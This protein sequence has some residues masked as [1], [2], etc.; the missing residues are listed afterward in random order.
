MQTAIFLFGFKKVDISVSAYKRLKSYPLE[1][2]TNGTHI[3][4]YDSLVHESR[5]VTSGISYC[6]IDYWYGHFKRL[7]K[8]KLTNSAQ[9]FASMCLS[10][11]CL[12]LVHV[13]C[14]Q[15]VDVNYLRELE[16]A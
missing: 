16:F 13:D 3:Y 10:T 12:V 9:T 2:Y 4:M 15:L 11:G 1:N 7:C 6:I 5:R 8:L 14:G